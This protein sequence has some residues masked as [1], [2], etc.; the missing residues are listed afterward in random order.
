M[1]ETQEEVLGKIT[2]AT[3]RQSQNI[4]I[5]AG[6]VEKLAEQVDDRPTKK[7]AYG[8]SLLIGAVT[9][10]LVGAMFLGVRDVSQSNQSILHD[11]QS[12][13][14]V[15]AEGT[16]AE[17]GQ[18]RT[19]LAVATLN[20]NVE[21]VVYFIEPSYLPLEYCYEYINAEV[22]KQKEGGSPVGDVPKLD[23]KKVEG[24]PQVPA[25]KTP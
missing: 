4:G 18:E 15:E 2:E 5:L 10:L 25:A 1:E 17:E 22:E 23:L 7:S 24:I 8:L 13:I 20:C 16:C 3:A 14:E 12:C 19:A 9:L 21:K 11:L 6:A